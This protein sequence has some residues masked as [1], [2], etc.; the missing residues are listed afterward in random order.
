MEEEIT[1]RVKT[2]W[3]NILI[4]ENQVW[5]EITEFIDRKVQ[6][7]QNHLE[8]NKEELEKKKQEIKEKQVNENTNEIKKLVNREVNLIKPMECCCVDNRNIFNG[9]IKKLTE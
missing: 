3:E 5:T 7:I 9:N 2:L 1:K 8:N 4:R 6:N